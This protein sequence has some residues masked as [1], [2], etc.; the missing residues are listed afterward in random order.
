MRQ[1]DNQLNYDEIRGRETEDYINE[2]V[3]IRTN[4]Y[5]SPNEYSPEDQLET[6]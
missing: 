1:K 6:E 4:H 3:P 5:E 2:F